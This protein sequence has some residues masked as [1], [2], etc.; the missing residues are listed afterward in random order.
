MAAAGVPTARALVC[1]TRAEAE[2]AL[3][4]LGAPYVVKDDGLAA[5]K[6]VVVTDDREAAVAH[7]ASCDRVVVEEFLDGPEVS[8]FALCSY[9]ETDGA[10]VRPLQPAQ[11]FKRIGDGDE[12]PNTGGMGA[13]TP[14]P[15][16]PADLVEEVL[17]RRAAAHGRRD[18]A[19]GHA[20]HRAALR[21]PRADQ[22]RAPGSSSS[23]P[24][25]ATPRPSRCWRCSTPRS[26]R[27]STPRR[28]GPSAGSTRR[29]GSPARPWRS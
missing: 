9:D 28:P 20:V 7:A 6:G 1:E 11:D 27:C 12:G 24:G 10:C 15:W 17:P 23:T 13:Y 19:P 21:R 22:P 2:A 16:A 4:E 8:L 14:L 3:D 25:S 5:G 18:G 29:R 26:A